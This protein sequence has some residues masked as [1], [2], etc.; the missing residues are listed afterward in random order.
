MYVRS[1]GPHELC[2]HVNRVIWV[3]LLQP[4]RAQNDTQTRALLWKCVYFGHLAV[5]V[6][7][8][9]PRVRKLY[10]LRGR[11]SIVARR[12]GLTAWSVGEGKEM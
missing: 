9:S 1:S 12:L 4:P 5:C 7:G 2:I 3:S 10:S 6:C 11:E 8:V